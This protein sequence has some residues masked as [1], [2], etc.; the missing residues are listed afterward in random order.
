[1]KINTSHHIGGKIMM[2]KKTIVLLLPVAA[3][4][5][6]LRR[7][8]RNRAMPDYAFY[9]SSPAIAQRQGR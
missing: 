6:G 5:S 4:F 8:D 3:C 9:K 1:M 7:G 2:N